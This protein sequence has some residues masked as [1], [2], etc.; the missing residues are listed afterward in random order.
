MKSAY[1]ISS[2]LE[3]V[4]SID[5]DGDLNR[6]S[7]HCNKSVMTKDSIEKTKKKNG[8]KSKKGGKKE[9]SSS[10]SSSSD[11][12]SSIPSFSLGAALE[13]V[14]GVSLKQKDFGR[15]LD[16]NDTFC[17]LGTVGEAELSKSPV[18]NSNNSTTTTTT[19]VK[20]TKRSEIKQSQ[21]KMMANPYM[22]NNNN[23]SPFANFG[24]NDD[25]ETENEEDLFET[26]F[27]N[28]PFKMPTYLG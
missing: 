8:S 24:S 18:K 23:K 14:G 22:S 21:P 17:G 16:D 1:D 9:K 28:N 20:T 15:G 10:T 11:G 13:K 12:T 25:D 7:E 5:N 27:E 3:G 2:L 4:D 6:G 19:K 26:R